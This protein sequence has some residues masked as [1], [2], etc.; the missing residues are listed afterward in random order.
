[1]KKITKKHIFSLD[2]LA[3]G[4]GNDNV[5]INGYRI[6]SRHRTG[7]LCF[8]RDLE[9]EPDSRKIDAAPQLYS[10]SKTNARDSGRTWWSRTGPSAVRRREPSCWRPQQTGPAAL[11][12]QSGPAPAPVPPHPDQQGKNELTASPYGR[13]LP[14]KYV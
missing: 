13:T 14:Q 6:R 8:D 2:F 10:L 3:P 7:H 12:P 5:L 4:S 9:P 1:M 11:L